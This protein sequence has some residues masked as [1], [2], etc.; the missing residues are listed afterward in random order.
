MH[1]ASARSPKLL[2]VSLLLAALILPSIS[3]TTITS[4]FASPTP[5]AT[6]TPTNT[7]TPTP[8]PTPESILRPAERAGYLVILRTVDNAVRAKFTAVRD[9]LAG[10]GYT[11]Q[12]DEGPSAV[13]D[14]DIILFGALACNTAIDDLELILAGRLDI[15][16]LTRMRF[17]PADSGYERKTIVIQIIDANRFGPD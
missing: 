16:R 8:K 3:C 10:Q 6:A 11:V 7:P 2:C 15:T 13:G 1:P 9:Y 14:M 4:L 12:M 17:D 5:T